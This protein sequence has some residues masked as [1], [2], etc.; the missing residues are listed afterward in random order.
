MEIEDARAQV[1]LPH[2]HRPLRIAPARTRP[3]AHPLN[4]VA[5][6]VLAAGIDAAPLS[7]GTVL[8]LGRRMILLSALSQNIG[9]GLM[10]GSFGTLVVD[11]ERKME[12]ERG[13]STAGAALVIL[14]IGA[15][16]P[17]LGVLMRKFGLRALMMT[18]ALLCGSGYLAAAL[19]TNIVALLL[20]YALLVGPGIAM[21][22]IAV[23]TSL[24]AN[25]FVLGRG[26]A[27]GIV[28]MPIAVALVPPVTAALLPWLGLSGVYL[29]L[30]G[31]S[32]LLIPGLF[33][34]IDH[35]ERIG[36][37]PHGEAPEATFDAAAKPIGA[38][39]LIR[40]GDYWL[41]GLAAAILGG[42]G[43]TLATHIMPMAIGEG[44]APALAALL[45][46]V[47]GASGVA[48]SLLY[49]ML[50]DKIG[51]GRAL[52]LNAAIQAVLWCVLLVPMA[53]PLRL[54]L[55]ALIGI[56]AG[57]MMSTLGTAMSQRFGAAAL[58][59]A[60][61]LWS[62]MNL[63]FTVGMPPFA[64]ALY[65]RSGGYGIA[66]QVQITLFLVAAAL[67]TLAARRAAQSGLISSPASG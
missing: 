40:T 9:T 37:K 55:A 50:A 14:T 38:G 2:R 21:L 61:G 15:I 27:I 51:G 41:L 23:P 17:F 58:G 65:A 63:P 56:N 25:W 66:F 48:G 57:G 36:L 39:A 45:I 5:E 26:K 52:A 8:R 10:F 28:N 6:P 19:A 13:L 35:P 34:V 67:A 1:V 42:G 43:A 60:L 46:S 62:L 12:V 20:A 29:V 4:V 54:L 33:W 7:P 59:S 24:V 11:I 16:A 3:M 22:G 49:G 53:F 47:L 44:T 30:A 32:V 18:G 31:T 64:G